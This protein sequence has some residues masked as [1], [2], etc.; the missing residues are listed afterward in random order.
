MPGG[1]P[2]RAG[3]RV[4]GRQRSRDGGP[5]HQ[6]ALQPGCLGAACPAVLAWPGSYNVWP[7]NGNADQGRPSDP[8]PCTPWAP[9]PCPLTCRALGASWLQCIITVNV[10]VVTTPP[11][12]CCRHRLSKAAPGRTKVNGIPGSCP[13]PVSSRP[14][15]TSHDCARVQTGPWG[16]EVEE[17]SGLAGQTPKS[18]LQH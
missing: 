6:P 5:G 8:Y 3:L 1:D 9:Q 11:R 4:Q 17:Q 16:V 15:L 13:L 18:K 14:P 2:E 10:A 7:E 12:N